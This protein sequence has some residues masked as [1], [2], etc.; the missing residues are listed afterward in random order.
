MFTLGKQTLLDTL[1][2]KLYFYYSIFLNFIYQITKSCFYHSILLGFSY[3]VNFKCI[4]TEMRSTFCSSNS[5][6]HIFYK[7]V[8]C[9][10]YPFYKITINP[11]PSNNLSLKTNNCVDRVAKVQLRCFEIWKRFTSLVCTIFKVNMDQPVSISSVPNRE[12][13][14]NGISIIQQFQNWFP[15]NNWSPF[16]N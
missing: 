14:R 13:A 9:I 10:L 1:F 6:L 11:I 8:W 7:V 5:T 15:I 4:I 12:K 16:Q 3:W 2:T